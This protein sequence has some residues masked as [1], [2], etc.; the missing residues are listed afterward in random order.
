MKIRIIVLL[1]A[2]NSDRQATPSHCALLLL[3]KGL[4]EAYSKVRQKI[5]WFEA[6]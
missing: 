5:T 3:S 2:L 4:L 6:E 1:A